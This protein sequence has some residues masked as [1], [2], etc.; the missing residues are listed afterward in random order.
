MKCIKSREN[1]L[2]LTH[3]FAHVDIV[4]FFMSLR[5]IKD[6]DFLKPHKFQ[7]ISK[8]LSWFI[9]PFIHSSLLNVLGSFSFNFFKQLTNS[10]HVRLLEVK[11]FSHVTEL[12]CF[13]R[14]WWGG[15]TP[16]FRKTPIVQNL[17]KVT[18]FLPVLNK[19][20]FKILVGKAPSHD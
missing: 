5:M 18:K 4:R 6:T 14:R 20:H 10:N 12:E 15:G 7:L 19:A 2:F 13:W 17:K 3:K 1:L 9:L 8:N 16:W 11:N